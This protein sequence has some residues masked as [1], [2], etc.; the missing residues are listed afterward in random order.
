MDRQRT[1]DLGRARRPVDDPADRAHQHRQRKRPGAGQRPRAGMRQAQQG[2]DRGPFR[3]HDGQADRRRRPAA[4]KALVA[5]HIDSWENGSQ[6]WT[7]RMREEFQRRRGYDL[8]AVP[9]GDDRPRRRQPGDFRAVPVGPAA[10]DLRAGRGELRRPPAR[11]GP[12]ARPAVSRSRPTAAPATICPMRPS[13]TSRWASSGSAAASI[14]TVPA[15]WPRPH[16]YGKPIVGAE[17]FTAGDQERWRDHPATI[18]ALGDRAFC[19]GINRFVF[20]RYAMQPWLDRRPGMTMGPWGTHYERTQTWWELTPGWHEYLARCQFLLR[21]GTFVADLCYLH[22]EDS[23]QGLPGHR[24]AGLR[25][26]PVQSGNR[27][28]ADDR[29]RRPARVARRHELSHSGAF[30]R[31]ADDAG[32]AA[33]DQGAGR[34]RGDGRWAAADSLAQSERTIRSVTRKCGGWPVK[35]GVIATDRR[36]S[37]HRLG[38]G[39]IVWGP[40][41]GGGFGAGRRS[42]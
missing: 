36:S 32:A 30:R 10:D 41:A 17:S 38:R 18:K 42:G 15:A 9:A 35:S 33:Q 40:D 22:A 37:E 23:P 29:P 34:G 5:T 16:T 3:R 14:E 21:Q 28:D 13:A 11:A 12:P 4:G 25:L 24:R 20:H 6:N 19:E 2:G 26:G 7:A 1:A 31:T 27:A 8:L 39:R